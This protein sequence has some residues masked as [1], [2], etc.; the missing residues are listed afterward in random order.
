MKEQ[1]KILPFKGGISKP[2]GIAVFT[3]IMLLMAGI[4]IFY[5]NPLA[6]PFQEMVKKIIACV[7]IFVW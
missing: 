5:H 2:V 4:I 6:D 1:K 7:I 3:T